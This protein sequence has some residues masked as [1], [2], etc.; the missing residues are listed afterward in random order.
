MAP[1]YSQLRQAVGAGE[2]E[3]VQMLVRLGYAGDVPPAPR[4]RL[5]DL[6][7]TGAA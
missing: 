7:V 4:R 2:G 1:L 5:D 6:L 3:T